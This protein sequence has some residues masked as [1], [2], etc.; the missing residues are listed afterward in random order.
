MKFFGMHP[1]FQDAE[2]SA[3]CGRY[4]EAKHGQ[5]NEKPNEVKVLTVFCTW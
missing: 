4:S 5:N 2:L 1:F 3:A